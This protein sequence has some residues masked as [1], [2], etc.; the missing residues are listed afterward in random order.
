MGKLCPLCQN[1]R[2]RVDEEQ[3]TINLGMLEL[4][5]MDVVVE[6]QVNLS[7]SAVLRLRK[8]EPTPDVAEK[9]G[10][11]IEQTCFGSPVP[12]YDVHGQRFRYTKEWC[13]SQEAAIIRGVSELLKIPVRLYTNLPITIVLYLNRP[14]GVSATMG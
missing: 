6:E 9:V 4:S 13:N 1:G 12:C 7:E 14:E 11:C 5:C 3:L 8:A 2:P 10:A